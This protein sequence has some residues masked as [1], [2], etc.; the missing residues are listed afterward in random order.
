MRHK[1]LE[2]ALGTVYLECVYN[3]YQLSIPDNPAVSTVAGPV[4]QKEE[5]LP[6]GKFTARGLLKSY[7]TCYEYLRKRHP[8][9]EQDYTYHDI[10][11]WH[12]SDKSVEMAKAALEEWR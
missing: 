7:L 9:V 12:F 4:R 6:G 5:K 10:G 3:I 2:C 8:V 11:S 1:I